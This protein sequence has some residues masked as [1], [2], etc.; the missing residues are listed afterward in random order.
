MKALL[1]NISIYTLCLFLIIQ[2]IPGVTISGGFWTLLTA[3]IVLSLIF[4]L[5]KPILNIISFPVNLV[6]LGIFNIFINAL[7]IY[8]LTVFV[9]E[10]S[11]SAFVY[12]STNIFGFITPLLTFNTFFAYLYTAFVLTAINGFIRWLLN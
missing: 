4:I 5:F 1:R 10:V 3:G 9:T 8:L 2:L 6:T 12:P 7:L 11:I